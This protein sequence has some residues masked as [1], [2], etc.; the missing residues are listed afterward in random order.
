MALRSTPTSSPTRFALALAAAALVAA[1]GAG[2]AQADNPVPPVAVTGSASLL[3]PTT[4][5]VAG[6]VDPKGTATTWTIQYGTSSSYGLTT[7]TQSAGSGTG[8]VAVSAPL[9]GLTTY[10][11]YHFRVVA[12]NAAGVSRGADHVFTTHRVPA[13]PKATTYS[14]TGVTATSVGLRASV[15]AGGLATTAHVQW[16]TTSKYGFTTPDAT[17]AAAFGAHTVTWPIGNLSAYRTYHYRVVATNAKGTVTG[18]DRTVRTL[19]APTAISVQET[20]GAA[21]GWGRKAT[22]AGI[23]SGQGVGGIAL[24]VE[25]DGFPYGDKPVVQ[26]LTARSDGSYVVEVGP[27]WA[28]TRLRVVTASGTPVSSPLLTVSSRVLVGIKSAAKTK[29]TVTF[30][31]RVQP[32]ATGGHVSLQRRSS[33]GAWHRVGRAGLT[34]AGAYASRY[35]VRVPRPKRG[36]T[37]RAVV[38]PADRGAHAT[39][40]SRTVHLHA[41]A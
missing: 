19:R 24:Q 6:T 20:S 33:R 5:T 9:T 29:R 10:T 13:A 11:K 21:V 17:L 34:A 2:P 35:R 41:R 36:G 15:D 18:K 40:T 1:A 27:L 28:S 4:A 16:G 37:F 31:G 7:P 12:T 30:S 22:L 26:K 8:A 39:G 14:A 25:R 38:V 3:E 23:V 32:G